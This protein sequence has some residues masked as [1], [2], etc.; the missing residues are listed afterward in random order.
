MLLAGQSSKGAES[1]IG[2]LE[3]SV[4]GC[5]VASVSIRVD[6]PS[7]SCTLSVCVG[8]NNRRDRL[9]LTQL[10]RRHYKMLRGYP[11]ALEKHLL[12]WS[13]CN[14]RGAGAGTGH[15]GRRPGGC[16]T[17]SRCAVTA[18]RTVNCD[19]KDAV[20]RGRWGDKEASSCDVFASQDF[21]T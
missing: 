16:A 13:R 12:L 19:S 17:R 6:D 8:N 2:R 21:D 1:G 5:W 9:D 7:K 4:R 14:E 20:I 11:V 3:G 10:P 15:A 18:E